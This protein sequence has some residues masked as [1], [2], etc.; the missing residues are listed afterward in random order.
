MLCSCKGRE[1]TRFNRAC[2][3][4]LAI[5]FGVG[6]ICA[7][8]RGRAGAPLN[9]KLKA[10]RQSVGGD[11]ITA[12]RLRFEHWHPTTPDHSWRTLLCPQDV[13]LCPN[14]TTGVEEN[15]Q[16]VVKWMCC[17]NSRGAGVSSYIAAN[18]V[19]RHRFSP[20]V[21]PVNTGVRLRCLICETSARKEE[22]L[23]FV[24]ADHSTFKRI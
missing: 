18:R 21:W 7:E 8:A 9:G 11:E 6:W 16:E 23:H 13:V 24:Q 3:E 12:G 10:P 19:L 4:D 2:F 14:S 15:S 1:Q 17:R 22:V 20:G 5:G